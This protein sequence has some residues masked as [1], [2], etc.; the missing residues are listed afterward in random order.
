[1]SNGS[2]AW[3]NF[4][5]GLYSAWN[6]KTGKYDYYRFNRPMA[7]YGDEINHPQPRLVDNPVGE[8]PEQSASPLPR[9]ARKFGEGDIAVGEVVNTNAE[10][11]GIK[12]WAAVALA[13]LVPTALLWLATHLGDSESFEY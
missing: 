11:T 8:S 10:Q 9:G 4:R 13:L 7:G 2:A 12:A 3:T 1:M 5:P 6:W